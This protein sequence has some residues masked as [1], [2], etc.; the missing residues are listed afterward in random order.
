MI[1][2]DV[3]VRLGWMMSSR[4]RV[5]SAMIY[6]TTVLYY[7]NSNNNVCGCV[8]L[9]VSMCVPRSLHFYPITNIYLILLLKMRWKN[10]HA[11]SAV[12]F[13]VNRKST[14]WVYFI[15]FHHLLLSISCF[16]FFFWRWLSVTF[17]R[18]LLVFVYDRMLTMS[19]EFKHKKN[20]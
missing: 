5:K 6:Y 8:W 13:S 20:G 18:I 10:I 12:F 9:Y 14:S 4:Q 7:M 19:K 16:F 2:R 3:A 11:V 17:Q 15:L 1:M